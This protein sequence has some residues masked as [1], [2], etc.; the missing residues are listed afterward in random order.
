MASL[1][2]NTASAGILLGGATGPG[3]VGND[4]LAN[5]I[6]VING[7]NTANATSFSTNISLFKK[8]DDDAAFVFNAANG[9]TFWDMAVGGSQITTEASLTSTEEAWFEY[10][11][12]ASLL[13]YS[14]KA[15]TSFEVITFMA[16]ARNKLVV[17]TAQHDISHASFWV[18]EPGSLMLSTA[19]IGL[20]AARRRTH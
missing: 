8:T 18:P 11:G 14:T 17:G 10:A 20:L 16:G 1:A 2:V 13:Y 12:S 19:L 3:N 15:S 9:F 6:Q 4:K 5:V 7:Y